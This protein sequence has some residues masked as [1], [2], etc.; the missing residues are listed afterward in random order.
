MVSQKLNFVWIVLEHTSPSGGD[1]GLGLDYSLRT[2]TAVVVG[3]L[4]TSTATNI[5]FHIM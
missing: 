3:G 4:I 1:C 2:G 5:H